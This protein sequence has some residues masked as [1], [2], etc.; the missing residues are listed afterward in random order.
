MGIFA[1]RVI[2][3]VPKSGKGDGRGRELYWNGMIFD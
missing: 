3:L 2:E 1:G